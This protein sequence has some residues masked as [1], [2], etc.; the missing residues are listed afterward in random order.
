M[1]GGFFFFKSLFSTSIF[2]KFLF[3][4]GMAWQSMAFH[5][6]LYFLIL[7]ALLAAGFCFCVFGGN[8]VRKGIECKKRV[9]SNCLAY[10]RE[11]VDIQ[12]PSRA[13]IFCIFV[14]FHLGP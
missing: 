9:P 7:W 2:L 4:D 12:D 11:I 14:F 6:R 5:I 3:N 1:G 8:L 13:E 10:C